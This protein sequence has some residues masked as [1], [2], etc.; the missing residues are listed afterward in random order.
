MSSDR[1]RNF[2]K[3]CAHLPEFNLATGSVLRDHIR[4]N[5]REMVLRFCAFWLQGVDG[6]AKE[7][8]MDAYLEATTAALDDPERIS[9]EQLEELHSAFS[10][11][12]KNAAEV[13]GEHAF[14]KWSIGTVGRNPI[15][16]PLFECWSS[17]LGRYEQADLALRQ[18]R[19]V[20][21]ARDLMTNDKDY[22]EAITQSTGDLR[23]VRRRFE[24]TERAAEAGR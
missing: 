10:T 12:M 7:G 4:M 19:I 13:F 18:G 14:R 22:V 2:L 5:D 8:S 6:Y 20:A 17:V 1:S 24:L 9:D 15:N 21:A 11:A 16:R 3:E 23:K